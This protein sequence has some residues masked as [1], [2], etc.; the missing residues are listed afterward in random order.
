MSI[1]TPA[2]IQT[3]AEG[4]SEDFVRTLAAMSRVGA[5]GFSED[6]WRQ[7]IIGSDGEEIS[8]FQIFARLYREQMTE[9]MGHVNTYGDFHKRTSA[10]VTNNYSI[11]GSVSRVYA[12][13]TDKGATDKGGTLAVLLPEPSASNLDQEYDV[14]KVDTSANAIRVA[15]NKGAQFEDGGVEASYIDITTAGDIMTFASDGE[16]YRVVNHLSVGAPTTA[17]SYAGDPNGNVTSSYRGEVCVN[18]GTDTIYI[19]S[20]AGVNNKWQVVS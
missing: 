13:A 8:Q 19:A 4:L 17:T 11:T 10:T 3:L 5:L 7:P 14:K 16:R 18:P 1:T 20:V 6:A 15:T 2:N 9:L 12:D